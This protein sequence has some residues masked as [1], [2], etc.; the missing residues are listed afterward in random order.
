[1]ISVTV[2]PDSNQTIITVTVST[3]LLIYLS[4][5]LSIY[6]STALCWTL[7]AFCFLIFYTVDRTPSTGDQSVT[8]PLPVHRTEQTQNK[9]TQTSMPQVGLEP[10]IPVFEQE[11]I[12]HALDRAKTVIGP[13]FLHV[14]N[15]N[16]WFSIRVNQVDLYFE[17]VISSEKK[18]ILRRTNYPDSK[19]PI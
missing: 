4:I 5:Y 18:L 14:S 13:Q 8:M 3:Y 16:F 19:E 6:G 7:A 12:V 17:L 10:T 9:R 1:M 2:K 11:K 15:S